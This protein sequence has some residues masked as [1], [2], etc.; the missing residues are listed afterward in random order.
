M[1]PAA[2]R[3]GSLVG[4]MAT[5]LAI[6]GLPMSAEASTTPPTT[7]VPSPSPAPSL[8]PPPP[9]SASPS[10]SPLPPPSPS[11]P[12][13]TGRL[14]TFTWNVCDQFQVPNRA[15]CDDNEPF[16]RAV[17][18]E[19]IFLAADYL[20]QVGMFQE[21]C[22]TT[23]NMAK[24]FLGNAYKGDFRATIN[25]LEDRCGGNG[26]WGLAYIVKAPTLT[27]E[28]ALSLPDDEAEPPDYYGEPRV[29]ICGRTT[30]YSGFRVCSTHLTPAYN[31]LDDDPSVAQVNTLGNYMRDW[32]VDGAAV[33]VG[34]DMNMNAQW[35]LCDPHPCCPPYHY[36]NR[37]K[38]LY[39]GGFGQGNTNC[40]P[41]TNWYYEGDNEHSGAAG[42]FDETT[43]AG[44]TLRKLDYVFFNYQRFYSDYGGDAMG[45]NGLSD[46]VYVKSSMTVHD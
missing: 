41:G 43:I 46:H 35:G 6:V 5:A 37:L 27:K 36:V 24:D 16:D 26:K 11:G 39:Y 32:A 38:P 15:P 17:Y 25:F 4:A 1:Y 31:D 3:L 29:V 23:Y 45:V 20:P 12:E 8:S 7:P 33:V 13:G 9:P 19:N 28:S 34:G 14:H 44:A 40:G 18:I 2:T 21:M 30:I 42:P 10:Q 22:Y